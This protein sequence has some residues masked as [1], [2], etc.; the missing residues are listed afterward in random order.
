[1]RGKILIVL[2]SPESK[3]PRFIELDVAIGFE[4]LDVSF[5]DLNNC[6]LNQ[7]LLVKKL[8]KM[9]SVTRVNLEDY[10][11]VIMVVVR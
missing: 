7:L 10:S 1:M 5:V 2:S 11:K 3:A 4:N 6:T 8:S 9:P